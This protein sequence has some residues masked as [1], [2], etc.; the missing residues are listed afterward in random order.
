VIERHLMKLRARHA[1]SGEE[2][3]AIRAAIRETRELPSTGLSSAPGT[4]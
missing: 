1:I 2:E 4:R 3:A